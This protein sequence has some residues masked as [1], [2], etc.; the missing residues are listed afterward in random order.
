MA[1]IIHRM[2]LKN[3][4]IFNQ[5]GLYIST[6]NICDVRN[7]NEFVTQEKEKY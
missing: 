4:G 1:E 6:T 7:K 5:T 3:K 2:Q